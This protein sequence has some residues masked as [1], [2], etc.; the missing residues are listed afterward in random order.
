VL[1][2]NEV[3]LQPWVDFYKQYYGLTFYAVGV[4]IPT[5][6]PG[7]DRLIFIPKGLTATQAYDACANHFPCSRDIED[8]DIGVSV[9][10]RGGKLT[11]AYAIRIRENVEADLDMATL[12]AWAIEERRLTTMTLAERLVYELKYFAET[13]QHLDVQHVTLCSGS[14]CSDGRVPGVCWHKGVVSVWTESG[15]HYGDGW[16]ARLAVVF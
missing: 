16:R 3:A 11:Q 8:L 10:E 1:D 13:G 9:N 5:Y 15:Y 6:L 4:R 14:R 2:P 12:S 7:Y